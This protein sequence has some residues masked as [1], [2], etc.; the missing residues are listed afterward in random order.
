M[1]ETKIFTFNNAEKAN[2]FLVFLR[3]NEITFE[4][5]DCSYDYLN[6]KFVFKC[7]MDETE[8][9]VART[10][11]EYDERKLD[12]ASTYPDKE[13]FYKGCKNCV[14]EN[15]ADLITCTYCRA[16]SRSLYERK[17]EVNNLALLHDK[18]YPL[19]PKTVFDK[20]LMDN[21]INKNLPSVHH[22]AFCNANGLPIIKYN[23][24]KNAIPEIKEL[25]FNDPA[26]IIF[27]ED[28]TKTIVKTQNG[29]AFD[30]EKGFCMAV[31]KKLFG[32]EGNYY[33]I[34]DKWIN[35]KA[36]TYDDSN[37]KKSN[38]TSD[39]KNEVIQRLR[40]DV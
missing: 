16:T 9:R 39:N 25:V 17:T 3:E 38:K 31:V 36:K 6:P 14:R 23:S 29:E 1:K 20:L 37:K 15:N 21:N 13:R 8:E 24:N 34:V 27:W 40:K 18:E 32:N 4:A 11:I 33:N 5:T 19:I 35:K 26:T 7:E 2:E 12:V 30:K 28:G 10:L 22:E